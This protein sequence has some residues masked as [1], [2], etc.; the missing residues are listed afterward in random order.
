MGMAPLPNSKLKKH[1]SDELGYADCARA[2]AGGIH[3]TTIRMLA[4]SGLLAAV[5][6]CGDG[7]TETPPAAADQGGR[8]ETANIRA[9]EAI[10]VDGQAIGQKVDAALDANDQRKDELDKALEAQE[11]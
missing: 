4:L 5:A 11:R 2:T 1:H 8:P 6:A 7:T 3:M 10:G 9:T